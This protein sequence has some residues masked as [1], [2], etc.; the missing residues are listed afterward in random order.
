MI[1][2]HVEY[3]GFSSDA[4]ARS[5]T[6][7]VSLGTGD[8]HDFVLVIQNEAFLSKRVR[9][10]DAPEIC[11]LRLQ[12]ELAACGDGLPVSPQDVTEDDLAE[13]RQSHAPKP[14]GPRPTT[15]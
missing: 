5:Y 4:V 11:F 9:Y 13:Y 1:R 6:L 14:P 12:R 2:P 15:S 8:T 7:R 10:Q 3:L